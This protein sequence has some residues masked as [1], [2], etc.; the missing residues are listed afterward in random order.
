MLA[1]LPI[2][3]FSASRIRNSDILLSFF[4]VLLNFI[5]AGIC[6]F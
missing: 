6:G 2:G 3:A 5:K 1:A 4:L